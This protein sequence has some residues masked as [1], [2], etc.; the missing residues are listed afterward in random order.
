MSDAGRTVGIVSGTANNALSHKLAD[1]APSVDR[2][3]RQPI[4]APPTT[5]REQKQWHQQMIARKHLT[6]HSPR[7][8]D[9][10]A[11]ALS[12]AWEVTSGHL[13]LSSR[14]AQWHSTLRSA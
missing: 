2:F 7:S 6:P 4:G 9:S 5:P 10:S 12:C 13:S 1:L 8:T 11:R 3:Q 14:P